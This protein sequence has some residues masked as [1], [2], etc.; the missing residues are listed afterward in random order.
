S[1]SWPAAPTNGTPCLSSWKPGPSPMNIRSASG[2]P[3]PKT[4]WVR[5]SESRHRVQVEASSAASARVLIVVPPGEAG[6]LSVSP[7]VSRLRAAHRRYPAERLGEPHAPA[8]RFGDHPHRQ[9]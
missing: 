6:G 8:D 1:S 9:A 2:S 3:T 4:T 7:A 5:P